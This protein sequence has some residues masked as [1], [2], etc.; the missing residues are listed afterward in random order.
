MGNG[1][2]V[3]ERVASLESFRD[4]STHRQDRL[5]AVVD[6]IRNLAWAIL[7]AVAIQVVISVAIL[8]A[9]RVL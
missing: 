4:S 2:A 3:A 9:K 1:K 6:Q 5:E 8:I 7:G